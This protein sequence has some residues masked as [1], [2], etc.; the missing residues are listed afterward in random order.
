VFADEFTGLKIAKDS[1]SSVREL[2]WK[3]ASASSS[4]CGDDLGQI[5]TFGEDQNGN[6]FVGSS[7]GIFQIVDVSQCNIECAVDDQAVNS[8][9]ASIKQVTHYALAFVCTLLGISVAQ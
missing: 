9:A 3:C 2:P 1:F 4:R 7:S 8:A 6:L 5:F